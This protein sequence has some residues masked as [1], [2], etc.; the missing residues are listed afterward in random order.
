MYRYQGYLKRK[1]WRCNQRQE[2]LPLDRLWSKGVSYFFQEE[3]NKVEEVVKHIWLEERLDISHY[4]VN[5]CDINTHILNAS[6]LLGSDGWVSRVNI[7][8]DPTTKINMNDV[9]QVLCKKIDKMQ[10]SL[11]TWL[12]RHIRRRI[13]MKK[14]EHWCMNWTASNMAQMAALIVLFN[15]VKDDSVCLDENTTLLKA[16]DFFIYW[17]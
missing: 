14:R 17:K 3:L 4:K 2:K 8:F 7:A 9:S 6:V 15:H 12:S 10:Q 5:I 11:L 13:P 1:N 16:T